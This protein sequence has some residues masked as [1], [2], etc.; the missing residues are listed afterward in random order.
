M[1]LTK[2]STIVGL[3]H[4][5]LKFGKLLYSQ[6][7]ARFSIR[8]KKKKKRDCVELVKVGGAFFSWNIELYIVSNINHLRW[9]EMHKS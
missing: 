7:F 4:I 1:I 6:T 3:M 2:S 8:K 5:L 9:C